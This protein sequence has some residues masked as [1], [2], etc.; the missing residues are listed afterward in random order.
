MALI[1]HKACSYNTQEH[2]SGKEIIMALFGKKREDIKTEPACA[3][4]GAVETYEAEGC[5]G[6]AEEIVTGIKV[7]GSGC[8]NCH[9][10]FENAKRLRLISASQLRW[11]TSPI[12]KRLRLMA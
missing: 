9:E 11:S 3:C 12:W 1:L 4:N 6:R 2:S 5:C 7:L 10:L 8:K